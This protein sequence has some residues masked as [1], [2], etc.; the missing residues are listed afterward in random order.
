MIKKTNKPTL[1][2]KKKPHSPNWF[3]GVS[4]LGKGKGSGGGGVSGV[5]AGGG[6]RSWG[7]FPLN[8]T[9]EEEF[10]LCMG[11][12]GPHRLPKKLP[13]LWRGKWNSVFPEVQT[14]PQRDAS[15]GSCTGKAQCHEN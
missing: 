5:H 13:P 1:K 8:R 9:A 7:G 4:F 11:S 14:R 6:H 3:F 2:K 12:S 10:W 15:Y